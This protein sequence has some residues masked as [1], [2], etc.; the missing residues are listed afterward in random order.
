MRTQ[1]LTLASILSFSL[2]AQAATD[3]HIVDD[4][5]P[6]DFTDIATAVAAASAGDT[7]LVRSGTYTGFAVVAKPLVLIADTD[8]LVTITS[9]VSVEAIPFGQHFA[10]AGM[11]LQ[12]TTAP[13]Y[14]LRLTD[15][16]GTLWIERNLLRGTSDPLGNNLARAAVRVQTSGEVA[17]MAN[18]IQGGHGF[19]QEDEDFGNHP[20]SGAPGVDALDVNLTFYDCFVNGGNGV[21]SPPSKPVG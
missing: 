1:S 13:A 18:T 4:D 6:A 14:A 3:V 9:E 11:R 20:T 8:A 2:A 10:L 17:F 16:A 12:P 15:N 7:L 19:T 21:M 5:G